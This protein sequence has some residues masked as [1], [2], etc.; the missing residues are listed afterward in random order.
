LQCLLWT[1]DICTQ[2]ASSIFMTVKRDRP[3]RT[4]MQPLSG[5]WAPLKGWAAVAP[6]FTILRLR[7]RCER[8]KAAWAEVAEPDV[9]LT[10]Q[11]MACCSHYLNGKEQMTGEWRGVGEDSSPSRLLKSKS[12]FL[13]TG[14]CWN[15][16]LHQ[17]AISYAELVT[18]SSISPFNKFQGLLNRHLRRINEQ[19][20]LLWVRRAL[21]WL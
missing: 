16:H 1:P 6:C 3:S 7:S 9:V 21:R 15:A 12:Q 14:Y 19:S 8:A 20:K 11:L 4:R 5:S 10:Y 18:H 13:V 17:H 2:Q